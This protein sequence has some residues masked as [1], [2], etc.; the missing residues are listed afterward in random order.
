MNELNQLTKKQTFLKWRCEQLSLGA[1]QENM[2]KRR[3]VSESSSSTFS[4]TNS[5]DLLRTSSLSEFGEFGALSPALCAL[6]NWKTFYAVSFRRARRIKHDLLQQ[7]G[8]GRVLVHSHWSC[9]FDHCLIGRQWHWHPKVI[10]FRGRRK[11][12]WRAG[13]KIA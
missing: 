7:L 1:H 13:G 9:S 3:S 12:S 2:T 4:S 5:Q 6:Y 11:L 10:H 8:L